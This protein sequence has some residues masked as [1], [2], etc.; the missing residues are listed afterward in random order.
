MPSTHPLLQD[1]HTAALLRASVLFSGL[2]D[3][4]LE[5]ALQLMQ[6]EERRY[7]R[8]EI[9]HRAGEP[10]SFFG[11]VLDGSVGVYADDLDGNQ[12]LMASVSAGE[13][14]GESLS[15]L[16]HPAAP[17]YML[18]YDDARVL[19]LATAP[20]R[21]PTLDARVFVMRDRFAAMLAARALALNDRIQVL[22]KHTLREKLLT[23]FAQNLSKTN[24]T[25]FTLPYDRAALALYLGCDRSA[26]SRELSLM[27][28]E[29]IIEFYRNSFRILHTSRC[30]CNENAAKDGV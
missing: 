9:L 22:A 15:Y 27:Q 2:S 19:L 28:R 1:T 16:A 12:V 10:I 20:L 4:D 6:A 7:T 30:N 26:L 18:A 17:V 11:L 21:H 13:T 29:G 23:F 5:F 24:S 14:F 25:T 3:A 8:G